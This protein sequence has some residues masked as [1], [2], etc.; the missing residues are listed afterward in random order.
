MH[1]KI[2]DPVVDYLLGDLK[3]KLVFIWDISHCTNS[4]AR[5]LENYHKFIV[6]KK[7]GRYGKEMVV[8]PNPA[9][10]V[11]FESI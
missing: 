5:S 6:F 7:L 4:S 3:K 2:L 11:I 1:R 10:M 8:S 9:L